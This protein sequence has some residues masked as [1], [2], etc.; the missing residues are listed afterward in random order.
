[1]KNKLKFNSNKSLV[2][3]ARDTI[4][5]SKFKI[6]YRDECTADKC[7]YLVK[8][9]GIYLM[10]C[11]ESDNS[12]SEL[13]R[14]RP[15]SVVYASGFNPKHNENV[16]EDAHAVSG[17]DFVEFVPLSQD[18]V[19]NVLDGGS[20]TIELGKTKMSV[21]T[22]PWEKGKIIFCPKC[23]ADRRVF[24]FNWSAV[25]CTKCKAVVDKSDWLW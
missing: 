13:G 11:Y 8:D 21:I 19:S 6:A 18:M 23:E 24:H 17:D 20:I 3:L 14:D 9:D 15:N 12:D 25:T 4:A 5:A 7:F 2:K 10:N 22:T 16:W 1:M